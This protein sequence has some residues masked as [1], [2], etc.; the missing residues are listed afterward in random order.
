MQPRQGR[1]R[2]ECVDVRGTAI[3]ENMDH[4][5]RLGGEMRSVRCQRRSRGDFLCQSL[6]ALRPKDICQANHA[7]AQPA[8]GQETTPGQEPVLEAKS[9]AWLAHVQI[10]R[11]Y[12]VNN[13]P[14]S[15]ESVK[16][17]IQCTESRTPAHCNFGSCRFGTVP[18]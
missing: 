5:L 13:A 11:A 10:Y 3:G 9:I 17:Q 15:D 12:L 2:I 18:P 1:F 4:P 6:S 7:Q 16:G 14:P 8:P